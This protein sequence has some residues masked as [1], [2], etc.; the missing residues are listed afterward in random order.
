MKHRRSIDLL[1][2]PRLL[3]SGTQSVGREYHQTLS[4]L[5]EWYVLLGWCQRCR[6][7]GHVERR[8]VRR[9]LGYDARLDD[10]EP[11]LLCS[12]CRTRNGHR[13]S[14]RKLRR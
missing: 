5:P 12:V 14:L 2:A 3:E 9:L 8:D 6:R 4:Y 7:Y 11:R 1:A 13:F 10:I